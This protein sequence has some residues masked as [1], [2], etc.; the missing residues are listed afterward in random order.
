MDPFFV[1]IPK[2]EHRIIRNS[3]TFLITMR[4][5]EPPSLATRGMFDEIPHQLRPNTDKESRIKYNVGNCALLLR[6]LPEGKRPVARSH[7]DPAKDT[8]I[9]NACESSS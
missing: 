4:A 7:S 2:E 1:D 3:G 9:I 8:I 5:S 6:R